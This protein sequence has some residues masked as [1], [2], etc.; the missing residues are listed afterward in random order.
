MNKKYN[1]GEEAKGWK[2][3]PPSREKWINGL[4][5]KKVREFTKFGKPIFVDEADEYQYR[6]EVL[7]KELREM[8]KKVNSLLYTAGLL[9]QLGNLLQKVFKEK[10]KKEAKDDYL[11]N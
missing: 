6:F 11:K 1:T 9:S 2:N 3:L 4:Q 10:E 5:I 8:K 7:Q